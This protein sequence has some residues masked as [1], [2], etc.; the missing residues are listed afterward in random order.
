MKRAFLVSMLIILISS[1][2][3]DIYKEDLLTNTNNELKSII[4]TPTD[5]RRDWSGQIETILVKNSVSGY[6]NTV[7]VSVPSGYLAVGGGAEISNY[8][9]NGALLTGSFPDMELTSWT[10]KSKDH[11]KP[12]YHTLTAYAIGLKIQGISAQNL[13]SHINIQTNI[14]ISVA[15]KP[16]F[17]ECKLNNPNEYWLIGGGANIIQPVSG[18]GV[19]LNRTEQF[20]PGT[21]GGFQ[22]TWRTQACDHIKKSGNAI[23]INYSIAIRKNI[24]GFGEIET[25]SKYNVNNDD[26]WGKKSVSTSLNEDYVLT[27]IGGSTVSEGKGRMLCGINPSFSN[28]T[29]TSTDHLEKS[30]G[31]S[32]IKI[33]QLRKK[34]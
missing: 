31:Q 6:Q 1:C 30:G 32:S 11:L 5:I 26:S 19:L 8:G 20:N 18:D 23:V 24:P 34:R 3:N 15:E 10:A 2:S 14:V 22:N 21:G 33:I 7:S 13:L 28:P 27:A 25:Y 12:Q 16:T 9:S 4:S 29:I 17:A